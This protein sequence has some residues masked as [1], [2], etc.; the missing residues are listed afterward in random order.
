MRKNACELCGVNF[1]G[2]GDPYNTTDSFFQIEFFE[3]N[4][5]A[6]HSLSGQQWRISSRPTQWVEPSTGFP[7]VSFCSLYVPLLFQ[8]FARVDLTIYHERNFQVWKFQTQW[9][10]RCPGSTPWKIIY[11]SRTRHSTS[12]ENCPYPVAVVVYKGDVN[13]VC[14]VSSCWRLRIKIQQDT[15]NSSTMRCKNQLRDALSH[16]VFLT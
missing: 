16:P 9:Q 10:P 13:L 7:F 12:P 6:L 8:N 3:R 15:S 2:G 1:F 14:G 11:A 4:G 5:N